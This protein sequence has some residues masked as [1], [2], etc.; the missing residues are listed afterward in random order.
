[1][2]EIGFLATWWVGFFSGWFL[3]RIKVPLWPVSD[4]YRRCLA[5]FLMIIAMAFVFGT[6]GHFLRK[7][8][9]SDYSNWS[10]MCT[11]LG[12]TDIPAFVC[13]AYIHN[14]GYI[15]GLT[16]LL[17]AVGWMLWLKRKEK[18]LS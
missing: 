17:I 2:R 3:A 18:T 7:H 15:G 14:A 4:V 8:H 5:G 16:G 12:V 6:V 13:V 11:I 10:S 9:T 1:M